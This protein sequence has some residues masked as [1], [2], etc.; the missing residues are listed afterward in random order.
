MKKFN[1]ILSDGTTLNNISITDLYEV[2]T[3]KYNYKKKIDTFRR[4][5]NKN[6]NINIIES[7]EDI[8]NSQTKN[9]INKEFYNNNKKYF[10]EYYENNREHLIKYNKEQYQKRIN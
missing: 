9:V 1:I 3:T 4:Y 6:I 8:T 10:K 7:I 5:I 2:L